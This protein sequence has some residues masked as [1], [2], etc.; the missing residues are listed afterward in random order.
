MGWFG[1]KLSQ[2]MHL[3]AECSTFS[4]SIHQICVLKKI[5]ERRRDTEQEEVGGDEI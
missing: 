3:G 1:N 2:E 5:L 4:R